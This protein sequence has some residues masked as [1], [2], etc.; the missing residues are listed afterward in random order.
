MTE[1]RKFPSLSD[2]LQGPATLAASLGLQMTHY[3]SGARRQADN[4]TRLFIAIE[5]V[6]HFDGGHIAHFTSL[7]EVNAFLRGYQHGQTAA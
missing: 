2:I 5:T 1:D 3:N 4:G 7:A 6:D